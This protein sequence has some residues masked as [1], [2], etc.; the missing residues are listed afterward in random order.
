M[1]KGLP[2]RLED[3]RNEMRMIHT[4]PIK[5]LEA[6][7]TGIAE[8]E[9]KIR[10]FHTAGGK[11]WSDAEELKSDLMAILPKALKTDT[12][13]LQAQLDRNKSYEDFSASV[14]AQ[15]IQMVHNERP[16]GRGGLHQVDENMPKTL[17]GMT[18]SDLVAAINQQRAEEERPDDE[19]S[20]P[21]AHGSPDIVNELI[22]APGGGRNPRAG[23]DNRQPR[24]PAPGDRGGGQSGD[25]GPRRCANSGKTH[26]ERICH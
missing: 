20:E 13:V 15:S 21:H 4:H 7:P 23:K 25:R 10:E 12:I 16:A 9:E 8:F 3:L 6:V 5:S 26:V 2:N 11:G 1:D 18:V 24:R 17:E 22:A 19:P 14:R